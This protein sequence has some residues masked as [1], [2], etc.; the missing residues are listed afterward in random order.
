MTTM[1]DFNWLHDLAKGLNR[2]ELVKGPA[3]WALLDP[4]SGRTLIG[5]DSID[6]AHKDLE[7]AGFRLAYTV[8]GAERWTR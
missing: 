1:D 8:N 5:Y 2:L 7:G 4:L 6:D 3:K